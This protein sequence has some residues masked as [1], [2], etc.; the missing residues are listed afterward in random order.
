VDGRRSAP[1]LRP[2]GV[3]EVLDV[4]IKLFLRNAGTLLIAVAVVVV[5]VEL[6][7]VPLFTSALPAPSGPFLGT[8]PED[9]DVDGGRVAV[10]V[11]ATLVGAIL[12]FVATTVATAACYKAVGD[13]YLGSRPDWRSSLAFA[14]SRL[15][16]VLWVTL[17]ATAIPI[18][19]CVFIVTI[20]VGIW[21]LVAWSLALP[22]LLAEGVRGFGALSRSRALVKGRWWRTFATLLLAFILLLVVQGIVST[23]LALLVVTNLG[24]SGFAVTL[25]NQVVTAIGTVLTTPFFA[26]VVVVLYFDLRVRKEGFDLALL[27]QGIGASAPGDG[28]GEGAFGA[29][30]RAPGEGASPEPE[31]ADPRDPFDPRSPEPP[32]R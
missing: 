15:G 10:V 24:D 16:P 14:G 18:L 12:S 6:M 11:A 5:P 28:E 20:P 32:G 26:A 4:A 2:L 7:L 3:G 19:I 27:A 29:R 23:L 31:G 22:A 21:L 25:L 1:E 8:A 13:A 9:V 17:L 30:E